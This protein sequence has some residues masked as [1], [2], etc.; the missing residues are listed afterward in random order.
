MKLY[1]F[2]VTVEMAE[3]EKGTPR[4][5]AV[6]LQAG[7]TECVAILRDELLAASGGRLYVETSV[8]FESIIDPA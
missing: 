7:L 4:E 8:A 5:L 6:D 2:L 1:R 3:P